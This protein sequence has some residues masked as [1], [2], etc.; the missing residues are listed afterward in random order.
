MFA[1]KVQPFVLIVKKSGYLYTPAY[2]APTG[3][4]QVTA[5][6][7]VNIGYGG[8]GMTPYALFFESDPTQ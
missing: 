1:I 2:G 7:T 4:N 3:V 6:S 8:S 5:G